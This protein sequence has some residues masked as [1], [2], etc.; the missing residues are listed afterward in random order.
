MAEPG[1]R[2]RAGDDGRAGGGRRRP[3]LDGEQVV[4]AALRIADAD[5]L[6]AVTVARVAADLGVRAPSLYNHVDGLDGLV[7][8]IA[9]R[10]LGDL[11]AALS[12]ASVGRSGSAA[13]RAAADAYRAY[14]LA[15]PGAYAATQQARPDADPELQAAAQRTVEVLLAVLRDW[16]LEGDELI[17][18]ARAVRSALHGFVVLEADAGF[19]LPVDRDASFAWLVTMLI[20]GLD[21]T[22][23]R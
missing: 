12:R 18:A 4:G 3:G 19:G 14:A 10:A 22:R 16:R 17:H 20:G 7:R 9:L 13:V 15:H 11:E 23:D 5:G 6:A 2:R 8:G 21:A 1:G